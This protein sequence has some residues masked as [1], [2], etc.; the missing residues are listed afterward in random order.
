MPHHN[1]PMTPAGRHRLILLVDTGASY[2]EVAARLAVAISTIS[3]WVNRWLSATDTQQDDRSCLSDRSPR[4]QPLTAPEQPAAGS[5]GS[6]GSQAHRLGPETDR[7]RGRHR[8]PDG[9]E[10]PQAARPLTNADGAQG[11]GHA[12]RVALPG[13]SPAHG[14]LPLCPLFAPRAQDDRRSHTDV[15]R[16]A[17]WPRIRLLPR[18]HR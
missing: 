12:L 17:K 18:D 3:V 9:V 6:Q 5:E 15:I 11:A 14:Y 4:P 8:A 2:R 10:D 7:R 16:E 1:S 13:R